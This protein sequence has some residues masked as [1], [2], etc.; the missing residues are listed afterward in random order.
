[1]RSI[2]RSCELLFSAAFTVLIPVHISAAAPVTIEFWEQDGADQQ[3]VLDE[4]IAGFMKDNPG[5]VVK[6]THYETEEL[7][8]YYYS[9]AIGGEGPDVVLGPNDNLGV[10]VP[11]GLVAPIDMVVGDKY[12]KEFDPVALSCAEYD[13]RQYMLPDRLGNELCLIINRKLVSKAPA[14]WDELV[15]IGMKLKKEKKAEYPLAFHMI[16]PFFSVP[17]FGAFGVQ[18]FDNPASAKAKPTLNTPQ[19]AEWC[20]FLVKIKKDGIIPPECDYDAASTL[21][22]EGKVPFLI[23]GPWSFVHYTENYSMDL[24]IARIPPIG[25]KYPSP[26]CAV[27]GYTVSSKVMGDKKK[28]GAVSLF[29]RYMTGKNVQLKICNTTKQLPSLRS[30]AADPVFL[31]DPMISGQ[32]AQLEKSVPMPIIVQMRAIW[33]AIK[34]VQQELLAG[35]VRPEAAPALMQKRAEDG[36]KALGIDLQ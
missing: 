1:M 23:N 15:A 21:F 27:K 2:I 3:A 25:G 26:L 6:R 36:I 22:T 31:S 10:F 8:K 5:I 29:V 14:T 28:S 32:K 16:E 20:R 17:F 7:R 33:D 13:G 4:A 35:K 18:M 19:M 9:S 34:P 30:A 24:M 12:L 11:A